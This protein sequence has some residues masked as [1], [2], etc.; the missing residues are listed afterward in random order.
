MKG[1]NILAA[2]A[3]LI[4]VGVIA[5]ALLPKGNA[6]P[7]YSQETTSTPTYNSP[8]GV[9]KATLGMDGYTYIVTP[10]TL[11]AGVPVEM[12]V[13]LSTVTGCMRTIV[14]PAMN[15][16]KT[17]NANDNKITFTP[18]KTGTIKMSCGMGMGVGEFSVVSEQNPANGA[19]GGQT[20]KTAGIT[21]VTDAEQ[22]IPSG[23]SCGAGGG[24][25]GCGG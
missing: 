1:T 9:Q 20:A 6:K 18:L 2:L 22:K 21:P 14:I 5:I 13:D 12:T 3:I 16:R 4:A 10:S 19:D 25:C 11:Q 17:V 8:N 15:V 23:G 24:G 7:Q